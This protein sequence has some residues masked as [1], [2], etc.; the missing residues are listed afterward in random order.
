M[1][2]QDAILA[3]RRAGSKPESIQLLTQPYPR[4]LPSWSVPADWVF[5]EPGDAVRGLD[6]RFVVGCMV[7]VD[8]DDDSRVRSVI[9]A[10]KKAGATRVIGHVVAARGESFDLIE[11]ID[12][13]GVM[14]WRN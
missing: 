3:A 14:T 2:G 4:G 13:D 7:L 8:G 12:T 1:R 6:L 10:A 11:I 9:D 5:I